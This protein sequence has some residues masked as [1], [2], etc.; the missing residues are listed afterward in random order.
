MGVIDRRTIST[1]WRRKVIHGDQVGLRGT[2]GSP[3]RGVVASL[4][5]V[6]FS[7]P[8]AALVTK[9]EVNCY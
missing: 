7:S 4:R 5:K 8:K 9:K 6:A 1:R 3:W 2:A